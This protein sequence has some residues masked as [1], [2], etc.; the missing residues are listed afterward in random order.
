MDGAIPRRVSTLDQFPGRFYLGLVESALIL[1]FLRLLSR[2]ANVL[3]PS[4]ICSLACFIPVM[5]KLRNDGTPKAIATAPPQTVRGSQ[6]LT[7]CF[8]ITCWPTQ[9]SAEPPQIIARRTSPG[10]IAGPKKCS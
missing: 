4:T 5:D 2:L 7:Y 9:G 6:P 8:K 3:Q 10:L 1:G